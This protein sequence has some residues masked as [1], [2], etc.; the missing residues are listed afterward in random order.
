MKKILVLLAISTLLFACGNDQKQQNS[1]PEVAAEKPAAAQDTTGIPDL[2][3]IS[4]PAKN[5]KISSPFE[6]KG[7]ARGSWFFEGQFPFEL[8]DEKGKIIA[9]G[10]AKAEGEWMTQEFVPFSAEV[11]FDAGS[12][13]KGSLILRRSNAS[14]LPENDKAYRLPVYFKQ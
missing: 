9:Q 11:E 14:G 1:Q 13:E 6:I 2:L 4:S 8:V 5:A 12:S 7:K 3:V 10:S